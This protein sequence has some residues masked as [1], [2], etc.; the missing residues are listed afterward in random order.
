MARRGGTGAGRGLTP[1]PVT[2]AQVQLAARAFPGIE[3]STSYGTPALKVKGKLLARLH[4]SGECLVLRSGL[5]DREIL[6]Q[7]D[8]QVFFVTAHYQ[9]HPWVLVRFSAVDAAALPE[10]IERAWREVAPQALVSRYDAERGAAAGGAAGP[11]AAGDGAAALGAVAPR[12]AAPGAASTKQPRK[13]QGR[14]P[15]SKK[16]HAPLRP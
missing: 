16:A 10:L 3:P 7:S 13:G 14:I 4:Q 1:K 6:I 11:G 9:D 5:L 2:F 8:P 15:R 12:A